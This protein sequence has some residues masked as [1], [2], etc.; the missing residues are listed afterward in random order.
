[1]HEPAITESEARSEGFELEDYITE[2]IEVW[3]DN[4]RPLAIFRKV[5]TRWKYPSMGGAPIGLEWP[6]I[7]PLMDRF[8]L[9]DEDWNDLHD[10]LIVMEGAAIKTMHEFAPKLDK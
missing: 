1:L 8:G 9:C 5:G 3:P 7:Y 2:V 6:S 10:A 4:E